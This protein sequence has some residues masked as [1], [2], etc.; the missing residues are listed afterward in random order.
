MKPY[1]PWEQMREKPLGVSQE[2]A[3]ALHA[4]E[5]LQKGE[6]YNLRVREPFERLI[7]PPVGVEQGV[8]IV[9]EAEKDGEGFFRSG[10]F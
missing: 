6:G 1:H 2:G 4:T 8:G 7:T 5:L 10:E 3:F 9:Y